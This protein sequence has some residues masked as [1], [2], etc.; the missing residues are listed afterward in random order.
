MVGP[1]CRSWPNG[2]NSGVGLVPTVPEH[3]KLAVAFGA[4]I[5]A[6]ASAK[7]LAHRPP[8]ARP[9]APRADDLANAE[10]IVDR[11]T[12]QDRRREEEAARRPVL[13]DTTGLERGPSFIDLVVTPRRP[14]SFVGYDRPSTEQ[15]RPLVPAPVKPRRADVT[16]ILLVVVAVVVLGAVLWYVSTM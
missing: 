3:P 11:D 10:P 2:S 9:R 14:A 1:P 15:A 8:A 6:A 5:S 16:E 7:I 13:V 12:S 4:S